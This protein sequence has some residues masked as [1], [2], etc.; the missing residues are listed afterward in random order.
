MRP[1]SELTHAD[2][3]RAYARW[4][5]VYDLTFSA[6]MRR[7]RQAL[8]DS[9]K[10]RTGM[11][12]DVGVGTGLELPMFDRNLRLVG[13]DLS[14]PMLRLCESRIRSRRL[15]AVL[16][17]MDAM[18]LAFADQTFEAAVAPFVLTVAP[19]PAR[20]LDELAR[21]VREGGEIVLVN[22][23]G[24]EAGAAA[25]IERWLAVRS[26]ALGWRPAFPWRIIADWIAERPDISLVERRPI[27]P[28]GLFTLVRLRKTGGNSPGAVARVGAGGQGE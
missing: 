26:A 18:D 6:V 23:I 2:V 16:A 9:L 19:D 4:A 14:E 27:A 13:V 11:V 25:R 3:A 7:G 22:H 21:V 10:G 8:A 20:L 24:A 15:D 17:L 1:S 5:P 28:F 12:L